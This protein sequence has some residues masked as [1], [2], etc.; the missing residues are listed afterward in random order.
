VRSSDKQQV[1]LRA[2]VE[3]AGSQTNVFCIT[4]DQR[5]GEDNSGLLER[6]AVRVLRNSLRPATSLYV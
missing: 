4:D 5:C 6:G 2:Q 3:T 1:L